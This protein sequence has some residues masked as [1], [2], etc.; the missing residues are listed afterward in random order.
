M[1]HR[2]ETGKRS[3]S[4]RNL[5]ISI[6]VFVIIAGCFW[7]IT[8]SVST[9]TSS[10]EKQLLESAINRGITHCYAIEG[11]Y[12]ES[13]DY[14]KDHYGLYYDEERFF[15]DYQPIGADIMP[16]FT[17]IEKEGGNR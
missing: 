8:N 13:L 5:I 15:I 2:F 10:E 4:V 11:V 1:S 14:L 9:K 12:P 7:Y 6:A 17:I 16:D 3:S